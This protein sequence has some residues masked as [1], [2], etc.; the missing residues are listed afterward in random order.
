MNARSLWSQL[1]VQWHDNRRLRLGVMAILS[2]MGVHFLLGLGDH[3]QELAAEYRQRAGLLER[4]EEASMES[5]WPDHAAQAEVALAAELEEIPVV[6]SAGLAQAELQTWLTAQA[7][8]AAVVQPQVRAETTL[9]V[10]GYDGLW[11]VIARLDGTAP[12]SG[13]QAFIRILSDGLPWVQVERLEVT[14]TRNDPRVS[15]IVRGY[16]RRDEASATVGSAGPES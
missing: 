1:L 9:E 16:Y 11:Q 4:L 10:P 15:V 3:N 14:E 13:L 5:A 2:I 7:A 12:P 6:N 8:A